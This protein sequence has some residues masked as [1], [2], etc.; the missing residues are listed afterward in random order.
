M[1]AK[2]TR[3]GGKW[4]EA[5][6]KSFIINALRGATRKWGPMYQ[7]RKK[8]RIEHG[9]YWC[10]GYKRKKHKV[11]ATLPPP[12]GKKNRIN[13]SVIDH[14]NPVVDPETGFIDWNTLVSRMFVEEDGLQLLCHDCHLRKTKDERKKREK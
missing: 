1:G 13:N 7:V 5:R 14:I 11:Q 8:A 6:F 2:K 10:A 12:K 9:L 4:T 3:N